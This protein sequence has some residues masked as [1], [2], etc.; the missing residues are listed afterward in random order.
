MSRNFELL[1]QAE[2]KHE[3]LRPSGKLAGPTDGRRY[4]LDLEA[5][6]RE[7]IAKL[8]QRVFLLPSP[9]GA[10]RMVLFTSAE[11]GDGCSWICARTSELLAVQVTG[12]VCVVD[13]NLRS[14][15][16]H[17]HFDVENLCGLTDALVQSGPVRNFAQSLPGD[18]LWL[19]PGGSLGTDLNAL[20]ASG[21][22]RSRMMELRTEF[23]YVLIDAPPVNL[24]A[25][26]IILG[27][28]ADGIVL[29]VAANSTRREVA[30][31]AKQSLEAAKLRLLGAVLN[32]RTFPIPERLYRKL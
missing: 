10:P 27:Q 18:N 13:A 22:L 23:D 9:E 14:P 28:L 12:S 3:L 26:A 1:Q 25:D 32:K 5:L 17:Q 30:R 11:H 15:S 31:K 2:K 8:V 24:Y 4:Q 6:T 21:R 16:L 7:E 19:V 20:L 29:V